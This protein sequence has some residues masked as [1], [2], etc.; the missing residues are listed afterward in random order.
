MAKIIFLKEFF[1]SPRFKWVLGTTLLRLRRWKS[2]TKKVFN[3]LF[4]LIKSGT[5][6]LLLLVGDIGSV[7][8]T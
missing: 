8:D 2:L 1:W 7:W 4:C 5:C 3:F 6:V